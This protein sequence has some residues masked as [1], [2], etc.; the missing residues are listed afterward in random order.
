MG[1]ESVDAAPTLEELRQ[2]EYLY[3]VIKEVLGQF[4]AR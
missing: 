2:M 4:N 1:R 3:A